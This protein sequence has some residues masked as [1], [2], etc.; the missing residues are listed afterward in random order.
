ML[1]NLGSVI[2]KRGER[3]Y[4][5]G[6]TLVCFIGGIIKLLAFYIFKKYLAEKEYFEEIDG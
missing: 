4:G 6:A 2:F 3:D 5:L 1:I